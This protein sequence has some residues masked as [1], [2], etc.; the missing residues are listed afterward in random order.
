MAEAGNP[1]IYGCNLI[2]V[3]DAGALLRLRAPRM[4]AH[5]CVYVRLGCGRTLTF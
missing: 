5:F 4:R 3:Q 1:L 2:I